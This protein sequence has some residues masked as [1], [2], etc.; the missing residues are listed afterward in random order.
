[1]LVDECNDIDFKIELV[2]VVCDM[3][4]RSTVCARARLTS[5]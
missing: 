4:I 5:E 1:M 3:M 2:V